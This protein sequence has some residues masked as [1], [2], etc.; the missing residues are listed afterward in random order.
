MKMTNGV[1]V[2]G[3]IITDGTSH[4]LDYHAVFFNSTENGGE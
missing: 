2:V 1:Y 4:S 3:N